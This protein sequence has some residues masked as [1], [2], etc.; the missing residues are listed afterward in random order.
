MST[1]IDKK[2]AAGFSRT[3][4][5]N[6]P[7][8]VS[9]NMEEGRPKAHILHLHLKAGQRGMYM[10]AY[11]DCGNEHE[12]IL[13]RDSTIKVHHEPTILHN[14]IHVWHGHIDNDEDY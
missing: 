4:L 12:F 14:G 13:P 11:G 2:T 3:N 10:G 1:S 7:Q 6:T 5:H 9:D 8:Q